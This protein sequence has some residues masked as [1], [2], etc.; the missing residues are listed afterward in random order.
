MRLPI[1]F[2]KSESV[3]WVRRVSVGPWKVVGDPGARIRTYRPIFDTYA[4][5][6]LARNPDIWATKASRGRRQ[7]RTWAGR[8]GQFPALNPGRHVDMGQ[9]PVRCRLSTRT[10]VHFGEEQITLLA[11]SLRPP[12]IISAELSEVRNNFTELMILYRLHTG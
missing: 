7:V 10:D 6:F 2:I 1:A 5:S 3:E 4:G 11:R 9:S 8:S 12:N